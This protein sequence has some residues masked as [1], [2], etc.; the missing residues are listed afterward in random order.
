MKCYVNL[1]RKDPASANRIHEVNQQN[2]NPTQI[3]THDYHKQSPRDFNFL[4]VYRVESHS[5]K[6]KFVIM[7]ANCFENHGVAVKDDAAWKSYVK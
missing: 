7:P 3:K 2:W 5:R 1:S 4:H 6:L